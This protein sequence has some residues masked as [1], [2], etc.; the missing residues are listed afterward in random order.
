MNKCYVTTEQSM[1]RSVQNSF[2]NRLKKSD[3]CKERAQDAALSSRVQADGSF[4][5][6]CNPG[7]NYNCNSS[8]DYLKT[9]RRRHQAPKT[10]APSLMFLYDFIL[11]KYILDYITIRISIDKT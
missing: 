4:F 3:N 5:A 1:S 10:L 9:S 11:L 2:C 6:N 8:K 7:D